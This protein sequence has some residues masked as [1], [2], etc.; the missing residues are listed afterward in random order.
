M[1]AWNLSPRVITLVD[2]YA[3]ASSLVDKNRALGRIVQ[4]NSILLK[5]LIVLLLLCACANHHEC[6]NSDVAFT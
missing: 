5:E 1:S 4:T 2:N 3:L 6:N